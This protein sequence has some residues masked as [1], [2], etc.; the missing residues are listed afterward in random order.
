MAHRSEQG[1]VLGFVLVGAVL[2]TLLVGGVWFVRNQMAAS[3]NGDTVSTEDPSSTPEAQSST[4][5]DKNQPNPPEKSGS[6]NG[7]KLKDALATQQTAE[8]KKAQE[9]RAAQ[10]ASS[11]TKTNAPAS[12][13]EPSPANAPA[14]SSTLPETGPGDVLVSVVG[15]TSLVGVGLAYRQSRRLV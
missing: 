12:A 15:A 1:N 9:Q 3:N 2:A 13:S 5:K 11:K 6:S 4:D 14:V 8:E 10:E 7:D